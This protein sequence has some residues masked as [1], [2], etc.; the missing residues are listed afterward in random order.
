MSKKQ[1]ERDFSTIP[2]H[3]LGK[4][5]DPADPNHPGV[6]SVPSDGKVGDVL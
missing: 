5:D 6:E 1:E 3:D 4:V 2:I